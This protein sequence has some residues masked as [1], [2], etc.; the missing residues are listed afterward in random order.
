MARSGRV[1]EWDARVYNRISALQHWLAE[2]SLA[3]LTLDGDERVLDV[4]CGDGTISAEIARR[5]PR[6]SVLGVDASHAMVTFASERFPGTT[7]PNLAFRVADAANLDVGDRFDL[8]V[9]FNCLHWV[10]DQAAALRGIRAALAPSGRTH[11][12]LVPQG[13][14][15]SLEDVIEDA[16]STPPWAAFFHDHRPPYLH[17]T[18]DAYRALAERCGLR[19]ERLDVQQETWD[20][21]TRAEFAHFAEVTFVEWTKSI[22]APRH[23]AFIND[24]LDRY[25]Q[26]DDGSS[27]QA[28]VFTFYQMEVVLRPA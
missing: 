18:P 28:D 16:V 25:R 14:R 8:V 13:R 6:G 21:G 9:S 5:L 26:V 19:T 27:S 3:S 1:T 22:P 2:K 10:R 15:R 7:H 23:E 24:V 12:R 4:G 11:L 17:L 20:F